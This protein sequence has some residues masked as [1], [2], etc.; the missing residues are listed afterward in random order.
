[1]LP[2]TL[3]NLNQFVKFSLFEKGKY[4]Q[5]HLTH[6]AVLPCEVSDT[7]KYAA[8]VEENENKMH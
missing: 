2:L 7:L 5:A 3:S 6:V 1:L 4:T 8:N